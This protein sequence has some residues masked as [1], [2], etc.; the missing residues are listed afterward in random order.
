M[1][2]VD[3]Q[4]S[5]G[6]L[7]PIRSTD[8][9]KRGDSV[10]SELSFEKQNTIIKNAS[11]F[12][13]EDNTTSVGS[14]IIT[15]KPCLNGTGSVKLEFDALYLNNPDNKY[16]L[17]K[18]PEGETEALHTDDVLGGCL[19]S[20]VYI[21]PRD[22]VNA[23]RADNPMLLSDRNKKPLVCNKEDLPSPPRT[24]APES[25]RK[26]PTRSTTITK[27]ERINIDDLEDIPEAPDFLE[28]DDFLESL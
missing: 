3:L 12:G 25:L 11:A 7:I 21:L 2:L 23:D 17:D 18:N 14:R 20:G 24:R 8:I 9:Y 19:N 6:T 15:G 5:F 28:D 16:L 26:K 22:N 27:G 13:E 10:L 1:L 4:T